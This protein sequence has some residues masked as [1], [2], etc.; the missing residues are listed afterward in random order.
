MESGVVSVSSM[1]A[2]DTALC[3]DDRSTVS[4][5]AHSTL[6][7]VMTNV[8]AIDDG[9]RE[10]ESLYELSSTGA[11]MKSNVFATRDWKSRTSI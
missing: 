4:F 8:L 6:T 3:L 5:D 9:G 11:V 2:C 7:R 10:D 1:S